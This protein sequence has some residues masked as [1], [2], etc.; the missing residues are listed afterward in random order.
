MNVF[1][2]KEA[3]SFQTSEGTMTPLF[4]NEKVAVTHLKIPAGLK[5]RPHSHPG[6]GMLVLT[7]GSIKLTCEDPATLEAGDMAYVPGG[8]EV[9]L[10]C[11][12]D[13]AA[14]LLSVPSKYKDVDEF[15]EVLRKMF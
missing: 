2:L 5:V 12:E 3:E 13:S 14:L 7:E 1:K 15:R 9:G 11:E 8:T 6:D 10:D 4:V